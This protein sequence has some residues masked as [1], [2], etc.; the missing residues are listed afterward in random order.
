VSLC[1]KCE[2]ENPLDAQ[3]C[4]RCRTPLK[5]AAERRHLTILFCDLVD[6]VKLASQLDPEDWHAIVASYQR[7]ASDAIVKFGGEV[8]RYVGDGIMA[9]FGF[10][11]AKGDDAERAVRAGLNILDQIAQL[12]AES[13]SINLAV[14]M[15][16][17]SGPVVVGT[18]AGSAI[19]AF[20]TTANVA[21]RLQATAEPGTV[22]VSSATHRLVSG[23][24]VVKELEPQVLKGIGQPFQ[25]YRIL[26]P[27][28]VRS[29]FEATAEAGALTP[30]VGREDELRT[31]LTRWE[32]VHDGDGQ[33]IVIVGEAG[34]GKSRLVRHFHEAIVETPHTW[35]QASASAFFENT[36]FYPLSELMKQALAEVP[37]EERLGYLDARLRESGLDPGAAIPLIASLL[38]VPLEHSHTDR[39]TPPDEQRRRLLATLVAWTFETAQAQPLVLVIDDLHWVDPSTFE[40]IRLLME[41][42]ATVPLFL[43]LTARPEFQAPWHRRAHHVQ[44][45]LD[46]LVMQET[47]SLIRQVA[48]Q[49]NLPDSILATIAERSGGV[50]LFVE[51]LTRAVL[52]SDDTKLTA[53]AIP[54]T[55]HDSLMA[56][57]DRLGAA[58][59]VFQLAAVLGSDFSYDLLQ[60][61]YLGSEPDLQDALQRL[62]D[63]ELLYVRGIPPNANYRFKHALI[64]DVAYEA[65]LKSRRKQLHMAVGRT[66]DER[67]PKLK[68]AQPEVLARH[69]TEAGLNQQ[70]VAQWQLAGQS[71]T[72]RSANAESISHLTKAINILATLPEGRERT[73]REL[74]LQVALGVPLMLTKGFGAPQVEKAYGRARD[75][76]QQLGESPQLFPMLF[77]LWAYNRVKAD[78]STARQLGNELV[79]MAQAAEDPGLLI[80]AHAAHGDTLAF[81]GELTRAREHLEQAI[82]LYDFDKFRSHAFIFGQDPGVHA[83]SYATLTL[84]L[85][86]CPDEARK[87]SLEALALAQRL[88]HPFTLAFAL[89]HVI[90]V[91]RFFHEI[92][93][94]QVRAEEL[95]T[96]SEQYGFPMTLAFGVALKGWALTKQRLEKQGIAEIIRAIEMWS[97]TG[98]TLFFKPFL[99]SMLAEAH[100]DAGSPGEGLA[101][102]NEALHVTNTTGERFWEPELYRLQG[103]L[104]RQDMIGGARLTSPD[105]VERCFRKSIN[106]AQQQGARSLELRAVTSLTRLQLHQGRG[107]EG[108]KMLAE[109]YSSFNEGLEAFDLKEARLLLDSAS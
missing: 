99:L 40:F 1:K 74:S 92:K 10:P 93:A 100:S 19:D 94:T 76:Y 59:E 65:L 47:G 49:R 90:H 103:E 67:F 82:E 5:S 48:T 91:H 83:L 105:D 58:K 15:G 46:R 20:G 60:A 104:M 13:K 101:L 95:C 23:L 69:W 107:A 109:I 89:I 56:R 63:A 80:E 37:A 42:G 16:I 39:T 28:G 43:L 41:Q 9:F 97:A 18:G 87:R 96:L 79:S 75:L 44:L 32:R 70:A 98:S 4:A 36:P 25:L 85:L 8:M 86:G 51:E 52:E 29:R 6:S 88:S 27:S 61:V 24:F 78:Y 53:R 7:A 57:L 14:R 11:R 45:T 102:L 26:R 22:L 50:P 17:D 73:E 54:A 38:N 34:I 71:A 12:N 108:L 77:G 35:L 62:T 68:E 84:W 2:L 30:F 33:A 55:L 3:F 81:S 31:L 106:I 64:R 72:Q 21:A 66:I